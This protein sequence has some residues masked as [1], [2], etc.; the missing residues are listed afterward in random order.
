MIENFFHLLNLAFITN[1]SVFMFPSFKVFIVLTTI[2][3]A[4]SG[5]STNK[6]RPKHQLF[7]IFYV[8]CLCDIVLL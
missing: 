1:I 3:A 4:C 7:A 2:F 6:L 5:S 8:I